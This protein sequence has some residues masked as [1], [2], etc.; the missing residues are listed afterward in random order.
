MSLSRT[1]QRSRP[2]QSL[3]VVFIFIIIY[4]IFYTDWFSIFFPSSTYT[5]EEINSLFQNKESHIVT[6]KKEELTA[7]AV[8]KP[9]L[10]DSKFHVKNWDL[11]G[12]TLVRNDE[13][14]RLTANSPHQASNMFSRW[15]IHA[16]SFEMELTFHIHNQKAKHNLVGDGL[17]I[18]FLD[19]PSDI[20]DVFGIQNRFNGLGIMLDTYKNGKRGQ[21]PY[22]NLM[23]GDGH[24]AYSKITDGYETRLAGC[25]AKQLLN[26]EA[27]ETKMRL[28]Y[29]KSGYLSLDFNYYGRHEE[30]QNC[31]TLTDVKLPV[32]KYLGFSAETGQLVEN[33]DIIENRIYALFSPDGTFVESIDELQELIR[34]QNEYESEISA[35]ADIV[36]QEEEA[37]TN[38]GNGGGNRVL[39]KKLS[40]QKRRSLKRLEKAEKRIKQREREL[41]LKKYGHEDINFFTYWLGK[42]LAIIKY[43]FYLSVVVVMAWFVWIVIRVQ[44]Q[45][46]KQKTTGLLD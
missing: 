9:Y 22:V 30:W 31:V 23:L 1:L 7:Q 28:V 12:N 19:K 10:D 41:R 29:L 42:V 5:P 8:Q 36:K 44:R 11:R 18:W 45:K 40:S 14:I 20:G 16:E 24:T 46:H 2:L 4:A 17:A 33:V 15:P 32:T 39:K 26:P 37:K 35:A 27:G 34:E 43:V 25:I 3:S 38:K 21:F 6:L 13:F